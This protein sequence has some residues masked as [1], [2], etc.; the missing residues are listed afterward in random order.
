[1]ALTNADLDAIRQIVNDRAAQTEK[2]TIALINGQLTKLTNFI[3]FVEQQTQFHPK[4]GNQLQFQQPNPWYPNNRG[5]GCGWTPNPLAAANND[6]SSFGIAF[7]KLASV[8]KLDESDFPKDFSDEFDKNF[9]DVIKFADFIKLSVAER[10]EVMSSK[11]TPII[12]SKS[13]EYM[14]KAGM[15]MPI[16][17]DLFGGKDIFGGNGNTGIF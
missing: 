17:P 14:E 15:T 11:L 12:M 4:S 7:R 2:L 13:K 10:T 3:R 8:E 5:F 1:M 16:S 6:N 9:G